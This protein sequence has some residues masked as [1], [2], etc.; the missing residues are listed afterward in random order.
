MRLQ[1]SQHISWYLWQHILL[2]LSTLHI[3][4]LTPIVVTILWKNIQLVMTNKQFLFG[5][6]SKKISVKFLGFIEAYECTSLCY[7]LTTDS[8]SEHAEIKISVFTWCFQC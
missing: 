5:I 6:F 2:L 3:D 8:D 1:F 4:N 7:L